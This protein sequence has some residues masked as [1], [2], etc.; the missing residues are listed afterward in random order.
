MKNSK[1]LF[2]S[3]FVGEL[4]VFER[5]LKALPKKNLDYTPHKVSKT[6]IQLAS[7]FGNETMM[8]MPFLKDG[9]LDFSKVKGKEYK[10]VA[11]IIKDFKA[12]SKKV[13][14][15]VKKMTN[16]QWDSTAKMSMDG[17]N[18]WKDTRG[19]MAWGFL[20]DMIHHRG[21][22]STYIRPMGGKVPSIYGPSADSK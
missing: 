10:N 22:L 4:P 6:A 3:T 18:E 5:V 17:K 14:A 20:V 13:V 16:A 21:Q 12:N 19:G 1:E 2:L 9:L 7:N 11:A 8:F 15:F